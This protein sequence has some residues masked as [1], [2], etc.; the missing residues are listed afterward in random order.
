[1]LAAD[2]PIAATDIAHEESKAIDFLLSDVVMRGMN[3]PD[4]ARLVGELRP[5]LVTLFMTGFG[6]DGRPAK[7]SKAIHR[8][9]P[10]GARGQC[11]RVPLERS[12]WNAGSAIPLPLVSSLPRPG[13]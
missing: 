1:M 9:Q 4:L 2:G 3:R 8:A 13:F 6:G 7:H 10:A 5:E 11:A 12:R